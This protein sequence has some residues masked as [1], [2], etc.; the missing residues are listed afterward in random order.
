MNVA[1]KLIQSFSVARSG[2]YLLEGL[3]LNLASRLVGELPPFTEDQL[4][5]ILKHVWRLHEREAENI[6]RGVY[7]WRA[8]DYQRPFAHLR[9][10]ADVLGDGVRVLWRSKNR[11][12]RDFKA[13]AV[14]E[15]TGLPE[16][17]RRNFHFQ[18]DGYL[19]EDSARRYDHQVEILFTGMAGAMRRQILP[20]LRGATPGR[21][22]ELGCGT[23][24]ATRPVLATF[25]RTRVTALDLSSP[26]LKVAR[27]RLSGF[28]KVDFVQ[29]DGTATEFKDG[30]FEA[31]YSVFVMHELPRAERE[32][33][34]REAWRV[35]KPG[36]LL[37][38][39][40]SLQT[41]DEPELNFALERFPKA[42]H[43]PFYKDYAG[44]RLEDLVA[45]VTGAAVESDHQ[46]FTKVV[47]ARK[48]ERVS[49]DT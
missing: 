21:W 27:D 4:R 42:Y 28:S 38:L 12:H 20:V 13:P 8:L 46:F 32:K 22:L 15:A 1:S 14:E 41:D 5:A 7:S 29:G 16:Y 40:D 30:A 43:E 9:S 26:Y 34:V 2:L 44:D 49:Q 37:V 35:L 23:G 47:W 31:V 11:R 24:S 3:P 33:L 18:T 10:L 48:E 39:A 6:E 19:S 17:Y 25:P 36:G 45:R